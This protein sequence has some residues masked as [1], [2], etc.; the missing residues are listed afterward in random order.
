MILEGMDAESISSVGR[1]FVP[2][3]AL[4]R[5]KNKYDDQSSAEEPTSDDGCTICIKY[6]SA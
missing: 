1:V 5:N 6:I 3:S 2:S 4:H